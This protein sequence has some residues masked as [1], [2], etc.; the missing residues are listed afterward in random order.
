MPVQA[1]TNDH[2]SV[3]LACSFAATPT[4]FCA[5]VRTRNNSQRSE[6]ENLYKHSQQKPR[7]QTSNMCPGNEIQHKVSSDIDN[8]P[9]EK[10]LE[11]PQIYA[12]NDV[13]TGTRARYALRHGCHT[14][15]WLFCGLANSLRL[16]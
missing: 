8:R 1:C 10:G 16:R 11:T 6:Y 3:L 5:R 2:L 4:F 14:I 7:S 13:T 12:V 15:H 9:T